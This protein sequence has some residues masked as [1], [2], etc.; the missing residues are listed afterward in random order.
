M[1][2]PRLFLVIC[3]VSFVAVSTSAAPAPEP[4][5]I[6]PAPGSGGLVLRIEVEKTEIE[7]GEALRI[8]AT[9]SN[10][11]KQTVSLVVPGD[12]SDYGWRTPVIGWSVLADVKAKHPEIPALSKGPRCGN[13]NAL[14]S[15]EVFDLDPKESKE[16]KGGIFAPQLAEPGTYRIVFYYRNEPGLK[17]KGVPLGKHDEKAMKRAQESLPCAVRSSELV[18]RV[19]GADEN[20]AEQS[21]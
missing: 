18:I 3:L 15:E 19:T 21:A 17:W 5:D 8:T 16:F 11:G 12:G 4:K 14:T 10:Q 7:S 13:V 2:W 20:T 1:L 6:K 9:I